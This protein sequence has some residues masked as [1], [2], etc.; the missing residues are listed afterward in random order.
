MVEINETGNASAIQAA[1]KEKAGFSTVPSLFIKGQ[2]VGG[3][4]DCKDKELSG[5]LQVLLNPF[6][7]KVTRKQTRMTRVGVLW[8]P[9]T[10]NANVVQLTGAMTSIYS[11]LCVIFY[12]HDVTKWAV[13]ALACD[14]LARLCFG[15]THS[16]VGMVA[17]F[18]LARTKPKF[19]A[20]PPKQ[21]AALC[22]TFFS[23]F[24]AGLYLGGQNVGGAVVIAMLAGASGMEGFLNFCVGCWMFGMAISFKILTPDVYRPYLNLVGSKKWA[25]NFMHEKRNLPVAANEHYMVKGQVEETPVDLIR[26]NRLEL[27]FKLEDVDLIRHTRVDF[28]GMPM[29]VAALAYVFK[30]TDRTSHGANFN[31]GIA[32]QVLAIISV[33]LGGIFFILYALRA[34]IYPTKFLKDWRHPV[35]GNFF[36]AITICII[37]YGLLLLPVSVNGG[38]ALIWIGAVG[39]MLIAVLRVSDLVYK[40]TSEELLNPS[41]MMAPVGNYLGAIGFMTFRAVY[42]GANL[43]GDVNYLYLARLWFAVAS[44]FAIVLFTIT[45]KKAVYDHHSDNRTRPTLFIWLATSSVAGPAYLAVADN[46]LAGTDVFFQSMWYISLFFFTMFA[47]GWM[48]SFF[49]YGEFDHSIWIYPFSMAAFTMCTIQYLLQTQDQLFVTLSI[50]FGAITCASLGV[51]TCHCLAAAMDGSLWTPRAKWGPISFMKLTH[52]CFRVVIPKLTNI[53]AHLPINNRF[54]VENFM[55]ELEGF[56]VT[57]DEHSKHEDN[58]L[59]P[60]TRRFFP[61]LNADA[62]AEHEKLHKDLHEI[63]EALRLYRVEEMTAEVAIQRMQAILPAW[64]QEMLV[65]LRNEEHNITV[66]A[67]KYFPVDYQVQIT[68]EVFESTSGDAWRHVLPY[69]VNNLP[70]PGW[71]VRY[72]KTLLWANPLRAQEIGLMLYH[73]IDS[74]TW[75]YLTQELPE[76]IPRGLSGFHRIY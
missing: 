65:H 49:S 57:F 8:F 69:I 9:E 39:Q 74:V 72:V 46:A 20:G 52:E 24:G 7:G 32:Y 28:F 35:L 19:A 76:L 60:R 1:L 50:I 53:L 30:L 58:I 14:F 15:S 21:F 75:S 66:V 63:Q 25:Y 71:K 27:E 59:F 2:S 47:I 41:I 4:T 64:G 56:I 17:N 23:V 73:G 12:H 5:D 54:A 13:L 11:I 34:M 42:E 51:S 36:S 43:R 16:F 38:G 40:R 48:K 70:A 31:T 55:N 26:K 29:A 33:I 44:L 3:C 68:K 45:F 37:L 67:R 62:D 10:V 18:L 6:V 22:G 61:N